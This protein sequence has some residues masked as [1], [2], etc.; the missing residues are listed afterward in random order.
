VT[1]TGPLRDIGLIFV[2]LGVA[3][4]LG[5]A[6]PHLRLT[7]WTALTAWPRTSCRATFRP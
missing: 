6:P 7:L 5:A 3:L 1:D 2:L 4:L